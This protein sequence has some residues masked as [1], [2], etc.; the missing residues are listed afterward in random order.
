MRIILLVLFVLTICVNTA[1]AGIYTCIDKDGN[2]VYSDSPATEGCTETREV[3]VDTLPDLIETKST[4]VPYSSSTTKTSSEKD[5]D[6]AYTSL[7]ITSPSNEENLRGNEGDVYITFQAS[8]TLNTRRGHQYVVSLGGKEVYKGT[9][10][11]V[12]LK[13]VDRGT[14]VLTAKVVARNGRTIISSTPVQFTLHR[15]SA[16]QGD[17]PTNNPQSF[18]SNTRAP[19]RP[20]PPT[21]P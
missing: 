16:L 9:Q 18:P 5:Q 2:T 11:S 4:P 12:T 17:G 8:P 3:K 6:G 13:N 7:A 14:H 1:Q 19:T 21:A 10:N 20:P 15:F